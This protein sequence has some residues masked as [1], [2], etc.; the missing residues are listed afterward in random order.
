MRKLIYICLKMLFGFIFICSSIFK[1]SDLE[2][3]V[4]VIYKINFLNYEMSWTI[5][6][7]IVLIEMVAGICIVINLYSKLMLIILFGMLSFF[8]VFI[9]IV[10]L[11]QLE[12]ESCRCFGAMSSSHLSYFDIIRN[13]FLIITSILILKLQVKYEKI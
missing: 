7:I 5:A 1:V 8:T 12:I 13:L 11:F 2:S 9:S 4:I 3:F 6:V 10:I